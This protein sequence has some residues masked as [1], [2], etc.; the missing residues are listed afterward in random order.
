MKLIYCRERYIRGHQHAG[1][2]VFLDAAEGQIQCQFRRIERLNRLDVQDC[3]AEIKARNSGNEKRGERFLPPQST[4]YFTFSTTSISMG[5]RRGTRF[6]GLCPWI[7][8]IIL[9]NRYLKAAR[10]YQ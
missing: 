4:S 2:L 3:H 1:S 6:E 9:W 8:Q 7:Q 10:A 5:S